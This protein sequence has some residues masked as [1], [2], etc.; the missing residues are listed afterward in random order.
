MSALGFG[1]QRAPQRVPQRRTEV[2]DLAGRIVVVRADAYAALAKRDVDVAF[3]SCANDAARVGAPDLKAQ[4]SGPRA[5]GSRT[6]DAPLALPQSLVKLLGDRVESVVNGGRS[7]DAD[8]LQ[9]LSQA[10]AKASLP[11][12]VEPV[13]ELLEKAHAQLASV[14][15]YTQGRRRGS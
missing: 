13:L 1:L 15:D 7:C 14:P 2:L 6:Y 4:D 3:A 10:E 12:Y 9:R 8:V 11:E 5:I